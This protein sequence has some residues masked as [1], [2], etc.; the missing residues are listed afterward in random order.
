MENSLKLLRTV[1]MAMLISIGLY[2]FIAKGYGPAP[3]GRLP[4][5]YLRNGAS[6]DLH[7]W[8][9]SCG[10]PDWHPE[11]SGKYARGKS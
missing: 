3:Q 11:I 8:G 2:A 9:H 5:P 6:G 1:Q 7:R 4:H 10:A